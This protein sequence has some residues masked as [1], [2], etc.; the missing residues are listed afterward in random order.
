M[1]MP[2]TGNPLGKKI[3]IEGLMVI[4]KPGI[5]AKVMNYD[6]LYFTDSITEKVNT[7]GINMHDASFSIEQIAILYNNAKTNGD[8]PDVEKL[9][10]KNATEIAKVKADFPELSEDEI[11]QN[12]DAIIKIYQKQIQY[13]VFQNLT[14]NATLSKVMHSN[15]TISRSGSYPGNLNSQEFWLIFFNLAYLDGTKRAKEN[16]ESN[17]GAK[18]IAMK[19]IILLI[20]LLC[21]ACPGCEWLYQS[22]LYD[23]DYFIGNIVLLAEGHI[24]FEGEI[25][26]SGV[27]FPGKYKVKVSLLYENEDRWKSTYIFK[28]GDNAEFWFNFIHINEGDWNTQIAIMTDFQTSA[29]YIG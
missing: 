13:V 7:R 17:L 22:S 2:I 6:D 16:S 19:F 23:S 26:E 4:L 1:N 18:E 10:Y 29:E 25:F 9:R 24:G 21:I 14:D 20:S 8:Y 11:F 12:L 28:T 3:A 5:T 15:S 27:L